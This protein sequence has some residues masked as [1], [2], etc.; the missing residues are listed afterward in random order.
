MGVASLLRR[1]AA[2]GPA[3]VF[4]AAGAGGRDA[5]RWLRLRPEL[6]VVDSPR[7]AT[8]LLVVGSIA[9]SGAEHIRQLHDQ[10][11]HPRA[12]V[13]WD[14][15]GGQPQLPDT[16]HVTG[17]EA[18]LAT[19]VRGLHRAVVV[20]DRASSAAILADEPANPWQGVG[21]YGQGGKGMTGGTPY[22]RPMT[23]RAPDR[24]GLELDQLTVTL[25]PWASTLPPGLVLS[26]KVQGDVIQEAV[27]EATPVG[28]SAAADV[29]RRAL[30]E[31]VPIAEIELGRARHHLSWA[32]DVLRLVG[33]RAESRRVLRVAAAVRPGAPDSA[34]D[35]AARTASALTSSRRL[36][37][38]LA[39]VG[40]LAGDTARSIGGPVARAAGTTD[41]ARAGDGAYRDLGF[42]PVVERDAD[43]LAR[44]R[45]RL[46]EAAQAIGLAAAAATRTTTVTGV[47]ESPRGAMRDG[48]PAPSVAIAELV[49]DV[50]A[51]LEWGDAVVGLASLDIEPS[52]L[53]SEAQ[54]ADD[55][56]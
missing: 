52:E 3:P 53:P 39:G 49:P 25:G 19:T 55:A 22:G 51:G 7:H 27:V 17:G 34:L 12:V 10:L 14:V 1:A 46:R 32:A 40:P 5:A 29:F 21:P 31:P 28:D 4:V 11:P 35:A 41:D 45:V 20:G 15:A 37:P 23:G 44:W 33:L 24:D 9:V 54:R 8:V 16:T 50:L 48:A 26:V 38:P 30:S 43:S 13:W 18:D 42:E 36:R 47:V 56:A 2:A 6:D